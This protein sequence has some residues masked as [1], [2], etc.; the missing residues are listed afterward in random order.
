MDCNRLDYIKSVS[1]KGDDTQ[2]AYDKC[3]IGETFRLNFKGSENTREKVKSHARK[4]PKGSFIILSQVPHEWKDNTTGE[5]KK[6][7]DGCK[8]RYL[9]HVVELVKEGS[10]DQP[11]WG[12]DT[13]NIF[14][15]VRVHWIADFS[16]YSK[17]PIEYD[18]MRVKWNRRNT[19]AISLESKTL[20]AQ[21][22]DVYE[23]R[24]HLIEQLNLEAIQ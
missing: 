2:W 15:S 12:E 19:Y 1:D 8:N 11:E 10:D 5:Q 6:I 9:T 23:L 20:K 22:N 13:W 14:R 4:L 24:N 17:I 21:W 3:P 16:N 18:V 7:P